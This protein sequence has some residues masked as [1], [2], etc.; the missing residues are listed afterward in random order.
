[1]D[2]QRSLLVLSLLWI[3]S[4][5][6]THSYLRREEWHLGLRE[7]WRFSEFRTSLG[8]Y[9]SMASFFLVYVSQHLMLI[10]LTLPLY[11]VHT[12]TKPFN[13]IDGAAA[14][15][16]LIGI[17]TGFRADNELH[18]YVLNNKH[19]SQK[20]PVLCTGLWSVSRHPN[21]LGEQ[22]WWVGV[23]LFGISSGVSWTALGFVFNHVC[24]T[25]VTLGLIEVRMLR[26]A[27]RANEYRAYQKDVPMLVPRVRHLLRL[28]TPSSPDKEE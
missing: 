16:C 22:L 26:R 28:I 25:F 2:S 15:L 10:G 20:T 23:A 21:H 5:R 17:S 6:L 13:W 19:R 7:D 9:W 12:S 11:A 4:L 18:L 24:D 8:R 3:W 27:E 1:M 14:A